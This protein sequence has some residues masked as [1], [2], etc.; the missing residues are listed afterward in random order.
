[1]HEWPAKLRQAQAGARPF[2]QSR[3]EGLRHLSAKASCALGAKDG[4]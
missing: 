4:G 1:L 3:R 2:V